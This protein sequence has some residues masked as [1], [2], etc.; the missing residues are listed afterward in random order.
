MGRYSEH[1]DD[2]AGEWVELDDAE[3]SRETE[4]A[5]CVQVLG[6]SLWI[7]KSAI[8]TDSDVQRADD[9]GTLI[10]ARWWADKNGLT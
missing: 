7:P 8:S 6:E 1:D 4:D 3:A 9:E 5:L 2:D 10:A